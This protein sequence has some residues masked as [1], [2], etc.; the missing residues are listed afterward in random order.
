MPYQRPTL[1]TLR[2]QAAADINSNIEGGDGLLRFANLFVLGT[3]LAGLTHEQFGYLDWIALQANPFTAT[4]VYLEAWA[5]LKSIFREPA[6]A[7]TG[8]ATF[9]GTVGYSLPSGS[10]F[11]R[12]DGYTYVTTAAGT[13]GAGGTVTVPA[14][15]VLP[16]VD[17]V[18]Y[19]GGGGAAGNTAAGT[20]VTLT[21]SVPGIQST[22]TVATAF[23]GGADIELDGS[24]RTRMLQA[25]QNTPMGGAAS[26]YVRWALAVPG[27]TRAWVSRNGFGTGTVVLYVMLDQAESGNNGFPVGTN[28]ISANDTFPSG[29][30]RGTVATGDQLNIA[31]QIFVEQPVTALVYV[32]GPS[33]N[34]INFTMSGIGTPPL[35]T[36][37]AIQAAIGYVFLEQGS[38]IAGGKVYLSDIET[39]ISAIS[40]TEGFVINSPTGNIPNVAGELPVLGTIT[41]NP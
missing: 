26:D 38:P 7:A 39:A 21:V 6:T 30:P 25:Y 10:K 9:Q 22:G 17:P 23:T 19:P 5:A 35:A 14:V 16:G 2:S 24:L 18:N 36:Q 31:N 20:V 27:V 33:P 3:V 28:G 11:T 13:V 15:A 32:C 41:Y 34:A 40:G 1:S 8:T 4:D 29:A 12:G 37:V